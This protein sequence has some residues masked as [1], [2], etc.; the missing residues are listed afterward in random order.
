MA[1]LLVVARP[2]RADD[3]AN[4]KPS[5]RV[6]VDRVDHEPASVGGTRLRVYFSA[7][8]LNG[9]RLDLSEPKSVK[10]VLGSSPLDAPYAMGTF[11]ASGGAAAIVVVVQSTLD[12][13]EVLPV[14]AESFDTNILAVLDDNTQVAVLAYGDAVGGGKLQSAKAASSRV[15]QLSNDG[16][17]GDPALLETVERALSILRRAKAKPEG[18]PLRKMVIVISDGRDRAAERERVTRLGAR[19]AK[20]GV[21]I[22]S[23][24]FSPTDQRRPLLLLG[25]L[26]KKSLGTFR[27]IR[28][29]SAESWNPAFVQ[30]QDEIVKQYV[31]TYFL[32]SEDD[33]TGKKVKIVTEGRAETTSLNDFKVPEATC[34]GEPCA[35]YC[36]G[37]V[38]AVPRAPEGKGFLGW[39]I[40][41]V[42]GV[43]GLI[44]VLGLIGFAMSK[45][46][47]PI[48]YPVSAQGLQ[49]P[50][51]AVPQGAVTGAMAGVIPQPAPP[52]GKKSKQG[53][54]R[55][56]AVG[57]VPGAMPGM[58]QTQGGFAPHLLFMSGPRT[59]ERVPL[60]HGFLVGKAPG[61][62]LLIEDGYTSSHHA[63]FAVDPR[64]HVRLYDR[65]S[66]NGTYV[67]GVRVSEYALEHGVTV[68]IGS[69]EFRYL[70]Q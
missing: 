39:V 11:A 40:W 45:R 30:L 32:S 1:A 68:R 2:V 27:W 53:K 7:R 47:K 12:Y 54:P 57:A 25:E 58:P 5:Y 42:G 14:I 13:A 26:S 34:S 29:A 18:R 8:T 3:E 36:T 38:C 56:P 66:T 4:A 63:Q 41:I 51:G 22:H 64:G 9:G 60:F 10:T 16:S 67:N 6:V 59:G 19:A 23:F 52:K 70:A 20:E 44:V 69:T 49:M 65:G 28:G 55:A 37:D 62:N 15:K 24:A 46:S 61:C 33:P 48:P 43:A 31:L 50:P 17:S 21:R 35:G